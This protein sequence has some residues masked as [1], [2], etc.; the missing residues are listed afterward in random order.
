MN[1]KVLT[2]LPGKNLARNLNTE[3]TV[4]HKAIYM[5]TESQTEI[6][7]AHSMGAPKSIS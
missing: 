4:G 6:L 3:V 2:A 7:K 1:K 5:C